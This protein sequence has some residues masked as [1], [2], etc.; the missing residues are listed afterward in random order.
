MANVLNSLK[1]KID[2]FVVYFLKTMIDE[3]LGLSSVPFCP[4]ELMLNFVKHINMLFHLNILS[5]H[6]TYRF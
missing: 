4:I 6:K 2:K 5:L 3:S 1:H